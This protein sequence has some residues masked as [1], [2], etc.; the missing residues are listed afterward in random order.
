MAYYPG[1]EGGTAIARMLFGDVNPGG[2]LPYATPTDERHLPWVDWETSEITYEYFHGYA[3]LDRD[4]VQ[5]CLPYGFGLSYTTF[6]LQDP[7]FEVIDTDIVA[8]CTVENTGDR[9]GDEVVQLY[10]GFSQSRV[11]RPLK[12]LRGFKRITLKPGQKTRVQLVCPFDKIKWYNPEKNDWELEDMPYEVY[13]GTS[14]ARE[15]LLEET[16]SFPIVYS[17]K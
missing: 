17:N 3:K 11:D 2:K 1:M 4:R 13:I 6:R 5:L 16:V 8:S 9:E 10:V 15:G 14:S 7:S 12:S